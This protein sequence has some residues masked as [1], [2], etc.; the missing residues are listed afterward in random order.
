MY[1]TIVKEEELS[2]LRWSERH[3]RSLR[4][5]KDCWQKSCNNTHV[6]KSQKLEELDVKT[7]G[8]H[9]VSFVVSIFYINTQISVSLS[10]SLSLS[11]I[12]IGVEVKLSV[13]RGQRKL[14][15]GGRGCVEV[16]QGTQ[17]T[18]HNTC[19]SEIWN[20]QRNDKNSLKGHLYLGAI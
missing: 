12:Y 4:V 2:S 16:G 18:E 15:G 17:Y 11:H 9:C 19:K 6:W 10:L 3:R 8:K 5:E 13:G 7:I 20:K 14:T 1:V